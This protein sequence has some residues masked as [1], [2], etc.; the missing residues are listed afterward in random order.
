MAD[1]IA[2]ITLGKYQLLDKVGDGGFGTVYR[3]RDP[4]LEHEVA[5]KVLHPELAR[6][7]NFVE[8][9]RRE[10]RLAARLRHPN[11]VLV[12]D[13]GEKDGRFYL[14]MDYLDGQN[15]AS[16]LKE[17]GP[18]PLLQV[19]ALLGPIAE[20]LD[21]AHS[22][23]LIHRDVKPANIILCKN[24]SPILTDFG[25]VKS[26]NEISGY[27]LTS[28]DVAMGTY[29]YMA[30]EQ[31][32]GKELTPAADQYSFAVMVYQMLSGQIPFSGVTPFEIQQ[33]HVNRPIPNPLQYNPILTLGIFAILQKALAKDPTQR[34]IAVSDFTKSLEAEIAKILSVEIRSLKQ[35][36]V[37]LMNRRQFDQ[38]GAKFK[39][40]QSMIANAEIDNL[41]SEC[42]RRDVIWQ[43]LLEMEKLVKETSA[44]IAQ[45][46]SKESWINKKEKVF[47]FLIRNIKEKFGILITSMKIMGDSLRE[48]SHREK[49]PKKDG[50][51]K[52]N[53]PI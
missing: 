34:Y 12:S 26:L 3:G 29:E 14:V 7:P 45:M 5:V 22:Q 13:V 17:K 46:R 1:E 41:L 19:K 53:E 52:N 35:E 47:V 40:A 25:L 49:A 32:Q 23:G 37:S 38:A 30:P 20:A 36:G 27:S 24:G 39:T 42:L 33:G 6:N 31:I 18:I 44:E 50:S 21:Y 10:A 4:G 48:S 8:R 15:M 11:I 9:F 43:H 16:M 28:T 2:N 51:K